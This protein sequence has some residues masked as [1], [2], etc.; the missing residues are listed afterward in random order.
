MEVRIIVLLLHFYQSLVGINSVMGNDDFED[1]D[2]VDELLFESRE[3]LRNLRLTHDKNLDEINNYLSFSDEEWESEYPKHIYGFTQLILDQ[4]LT[5]LRIV[6]LRGI[7]DYIAEI[8]NNESF[9]PDD[10]KQ[11]WIKI[12]KIFQLSNNVNSLR[13]IFRNHSQVF[14]NKHWVTFA[15]DNEDLKIL[16]QNIDVIRFGGHGLDGM[17]AR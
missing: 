1:Y 2:I 13:K 11:Q 7:V 15:S 16:E 8:T 17:S 9:D 5:S 10:F 12:V 4:Q 3:H 6:P 14:T